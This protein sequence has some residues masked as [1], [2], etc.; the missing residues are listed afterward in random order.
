ML[1]GAWGA[2]LEDSFNKTTEAAAETT[3]SKVTQAKEKEWV[4]PPIYI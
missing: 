1:S 2:D 4:S 3:P